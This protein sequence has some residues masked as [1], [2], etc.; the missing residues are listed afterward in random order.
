MFC[1]LGHLT[2]VARHLGR[3]ILHG[4][5]LKVDMA[6]GRHHEW[7]EAIVYSDLDVEGTSL[8]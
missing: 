5:R 7:R 2:I 1:R 6:L 8:S 3:I 4:G